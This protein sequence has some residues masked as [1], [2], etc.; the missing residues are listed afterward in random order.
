MTSR[1]HIV[2]IGDD[3]IDGLTGQARELINGADL[4]L[5]SAAML[6]K[7][8]P[9]C[10]TIVIGGDLDTLRQQLSDLGDR[11]AILLAGGDPLFY[12]IARYLTET[13]GIQVDSVE[14]DLPTWLPCPACSYRTFA[15]VGDWDVCPV[16]G[17]TSDPVQ[18]AIH[19][20]P[21]GANGIS[22]NDARK[23]FQ[24]IGAI[25]EAKAATLNPD[26]KNKYPQ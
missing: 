8:S 7:V 23:N 24:T 12:G 5:G 3:G 17:W 22:L 4:M 19:D 18:E 25:S 10:E 15:I 14:G 11:D 20:D 1:I 21:T 26:D 9:S 2:G 16:C 13:L 6:E